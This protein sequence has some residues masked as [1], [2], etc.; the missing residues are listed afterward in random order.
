ML[1]HPTAIIDPTAQLGDQVQVGPYA[2]V[3]PHCVVG[4]RTRLDAH[5][6]LKSHVKLGADC[7]VSSGAVLGGDPQDF[8]FKGEPSYVCIGQGSIIRECVTVNRS[9]GEGNETIIGEKSLLMAYSHV[10]HNCILGDEVILANAVQLGGH[11]EIGDFAFIGG[12]CAVHQF[13]KIGKLSI[14]GGLSATRQDLPP[15]AMLDGRPAM[16]GG[17]NKVGLK[18]RGFDLASRTRLKR[19]FKLLFFSKMNYKQAIEAVHAEIETD[20]LITELV[21]F[22]QNSPKGIYR[23]SRLRGNRVTVPGNIG[24]LEDADEAEFLS[25]SML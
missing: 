15:F 9:T 23:P 6:V 2:I 1:I 14:M 19:A 25:D 24:N 22:V 18:R 12:S 11:V 8:K 10:A 5:A 4:D 17:L 3:G 7:Q 21:D 20:P 13:V 16:V